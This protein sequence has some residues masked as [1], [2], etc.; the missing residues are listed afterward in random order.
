MEVKLISLVLLMLIWIVS[1]LLSTVFPTLF[2][3]HFLETDLFRSVPDYN[4][5]EVLFKAVKL[6]ILAI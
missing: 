2:I 4:G 3:V 5:L 6:L 1:L